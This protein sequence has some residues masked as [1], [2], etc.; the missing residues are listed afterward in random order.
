[1]ISQ[2]VGI[3]VDLPSEFG[4]LNQVVVVRVLHDPVVD[5]AG[6]DDFVVVIG[7]VEVVVGAVADFV[8]AVVG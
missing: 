1:L 6:F 2:Q 8:V 7:A 5:N 4:V 3:V